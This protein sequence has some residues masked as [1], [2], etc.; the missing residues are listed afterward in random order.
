MS[1]QKAGGEKEIGPE[2]LTPEEATRPL[3]GPQSPT[4]L[5]SNQSVPRM[6]PGRG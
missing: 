6:F 5:Q 3:L 4:A 2:C 1:P